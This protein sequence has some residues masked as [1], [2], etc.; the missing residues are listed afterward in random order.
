MNDELPEGWASATLGVVA[1]VNPRHPRDLDDDLMVTFVPMPVVSET[2]W[3]L[4]ATQE[5]PFGEVRT[6]YPGER[7]VPWV[8]SV[9]VSCWAQ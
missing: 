9:R 8:A 6:G 5:R 4:N 3:T 2:D 7:L 1:G